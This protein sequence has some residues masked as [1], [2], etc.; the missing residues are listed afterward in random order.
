V[1]DP[2]RHLNTSVFGTPAESTVLDPWELRRT[3][4]P[5]FFV[6]RD[7]NG[8]FNVALAR[9]KSEKKKKKETDEKR[10]Q[11]LR[12]LFQRFREME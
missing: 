1:L 9:I 8:E 11:V 6:G 7:W 5:S 10:F 3:G 4:T 12:S 2:G